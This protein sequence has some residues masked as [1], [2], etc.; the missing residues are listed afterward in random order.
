[1]YAELIGN[2]KSLRIKSLEITKLMSELADEELHDVS[3]RSNKPVIQ[4]WEDIGYYTDEYGRKRYGVIP[5]T[6]LLKLM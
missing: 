3:P 1:M 4:E 2:Y 6:I 5:K